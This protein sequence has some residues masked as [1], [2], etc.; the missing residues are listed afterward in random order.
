MKKI[1]P[2][3]YPNVSV[4][5]MHGRSNLAGLKFFAFTYS[6][7]LIIVSGIMQSKAPFVMVRERIAVMNQELSKGIQLMR[8]PCDE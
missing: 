8:R 1:L 7:M 2:D 6:D 4:G 3:I 5:M